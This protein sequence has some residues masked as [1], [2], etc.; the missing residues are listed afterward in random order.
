MAPGMLKGHQ[1]FDAKWIASARADVIRGARLRPRPPARRR[2]SPTP[3]SPAPPT[4]AASR[5]APRRRP[6]TNPESPPRSPSCLIPPRPPQ[7]PLLPV[8]L[9]LPCRSLVSRNR[10]PL[11]PP[12]NVSSSPFQLLHCLIFGSLLSSS[13][14]RMFDALSPLI[15]YAHFNLE[16]I[17][18]SQQT[19]QSRMYQFIAAGRWR[20]SPG[21]CRRCC[22]FFAAAAHRAPTSLPPPLLSRHHPRPWSTT[23]MACPSRC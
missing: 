1:P 22:R 13:V 20:R 21:C 19:L 18:L 3:S 8:P 11:L 10:R 12:S 15:P 2:L 7:P 23:S 17:S 5:I 9:G 4:P 16:C 14:I 6:T